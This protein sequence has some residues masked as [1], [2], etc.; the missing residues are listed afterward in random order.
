[1]RFLWFIRNITLM[2]AGVMEL[3]EEM[4]SGNLLLLDA[5]MRL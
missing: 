4:M 2:M 1:M 3:M 5:I